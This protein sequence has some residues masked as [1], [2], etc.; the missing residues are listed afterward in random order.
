FPSRTVPLA[1]GAAAGQFVVALPS[2]I[3]EWDPQ[4]RVPR[5]RFRLPRAAAITGVGGSDRLLW[6]TTQQEPA[7]IDVLPLVNRGQPRA[8]ELPEPIASIAGHP[9][10]DLVACIGAETAR[11]YVIDLDGRARLRTVDPGTFDRIESAALVVG[12]FTGVLAAQSGL[13]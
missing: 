5:R 10:S 12:R 3:E 7:R 4:S 8:H 6:M 1:A 13:P 9:K 2:A 11:L